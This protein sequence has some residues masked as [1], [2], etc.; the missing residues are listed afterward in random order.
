MMEVSFADLGRAVAAERDELDAAI[1]GVLGSGRFVLGDEV[2]G[3]ERE[4]PAALGA[5]DPRSASPRAPTRSS[6]PCA[7][8]ASARATRW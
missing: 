6:L 7:R 4:L 1:A 3:F 2:A 5:A 8:S